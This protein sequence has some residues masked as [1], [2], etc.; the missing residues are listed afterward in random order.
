MLA[1]AYNWNQLDLD[2]FRGMDKYA[3]FNHNRRTQ[4][5]W[6]INSGTCF[7]E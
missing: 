4:W 6:K 7:V 2:R 3:A 1:T 5:G